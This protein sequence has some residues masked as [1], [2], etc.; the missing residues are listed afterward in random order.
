MDSAES[1]KSRGAV[2]ET[3]EKVWGQ[4][5]VAV[6]AAEE[7]ATRVV[8]RISDLAGWSQDDVKRQVRELTQRLDSQRRALE[9]SVDEGVRRA[10]LTW[11]V[12]RRDELQALE[13]RLD[14]VSRRIEAR[15]VRGVRNP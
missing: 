7:E 13:Q 12:P 14:A 6:S 8:S 15:W 2:I 11:R 4:A 10:V 1:P 9:R 5:L 3:F